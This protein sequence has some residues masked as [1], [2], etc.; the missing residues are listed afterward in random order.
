[1][2]IVNRT[3]DEVAD[4]TL[5]LFQQNIIRGTLTIQ[6][7]IDIEGAQ[8]K[9]MGTSYCNMSEGCFAVNL[10]VWMVNHL[11]A[12]R[13]FM[14]SPCQVGILGSERTSTPKSREQYSTKPDGR[15]TR[16]LL[17]IPL[18]R[19]QLGPRLITVMSPDC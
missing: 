13:A 12:I 8:E 6:L 17:V 14:R 16:I 9:Q 18:A 3:G 10:A 15:H 5:D 4:H 11:R 19:H 2:T 1:M 7:L